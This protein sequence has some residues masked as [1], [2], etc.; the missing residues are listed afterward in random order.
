MVANSYVHARMIHNC[1]VEKV[2]TKKHRPYQHIFQWILRYIC[3]YIS[4]HT[5]CKYEQFVCNV[6]YLSGDLLRNSVIKPLQ[7]AAVL[8]STVWTKGQLQTRQFKF[9]KQITDFIVLTVKL[10]YS[11][12]QPFNTKHSPRPLSDF[13]FHTASGT[14][15]AIKYWLPVTINC[16][17]RTTN[18]IRQ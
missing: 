13:G 14:G 15:S 18:F 7:S 5:P 3:V 12:V 16:M 9:S 17:N 8:V 11:S 1:A 10:F 4:Q 6:S 2:D